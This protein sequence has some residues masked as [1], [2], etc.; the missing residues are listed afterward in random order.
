MKALLINPPT[1]IFVREDRCQS[2]VSNFALPVIRPP[3]DLMMM[4][5]SLEQL[6]IDCAIKDYPIEGGGWDIFRADLDRLKPDYLIISATTS[7]ITNDLSACKIAKSK[8]QNITTI[9]KGA[10]LSITAE[11][12]L[13]NFQELNIVITGECELVIKD[14]IARKNNLES[15]SGIAYRNNNQVIRNPDREFIKDLDLLPSPARHLVHN[16]FYTRLDTGKPMAV[17]ET[18]RGCPYK[19]IF[20]LAGKTYGYKVRHRSVESVIREIAECVDRYKIYDFHLK[21]DLFTW[22]KNW[23]IDLCSNMLKQKLKINWLCNSRVDTLDVNCLKAMR[24]AGCWVI[25]LGIESGNQEVLNKIKKGITL[26][27]SRKAVKLCKSLGIKTYLYFLVGFPWDTE[28][29]IKDSIEFA[30]ELDGD[31]VDFFIVYPFRG[32]ELE[33]VARQYNLLDNKNYFKNAYSDVAMDTFLISKSRLK[34]L[35]K[36]ALK[37]FYLRPKYIFRMMNSADSFKKRINY[38]KHGLKL[39]RVIS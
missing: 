7:T 38:L 33:E 11:E 12:M 29:T 3:M 23:I 22:D 24:E 18:S 8:N 27:Q 36:K 1:G 20:C 35:R 32:T 26:E 15:V 28:S 2:A 31:F 13:N 37:S 14:I 19:C 5:T 30:Q 25:S 34:F 21:S 9:A 16:V 10:D 39:L 17:I 6:S 4:A